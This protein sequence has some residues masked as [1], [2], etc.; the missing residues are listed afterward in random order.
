MMRARKSKRGTVLVMIVGLLAMLFMLVSAYITLARFDRQITRQVARGQKTEQMIRA[1]QDLVAGQIG[2]SGV[3]GNAGYAGIPGQAG[4]TWLAAPEI[5]RNPDVDVDAANPGDYA[6][7]AVSN[8][9]GRSSGAKKLTQL[10]RD[11]DDT[12]NAEARVLPAG[13]GSNATTVGN[14]REPFMDAT[15]AGISD[16]SFVDVALGTEMAN[17]MSGQTVS[18]TKSGAGLNPSDLR[19]NATPGTLESA[20]YLGWQRFDAEARYQTPVRVEG[21]GGKVLI[22]LPKDPAGSAQWNRQFIYNQF[23]WIKSVADNRDYLGKRPGAVSDTTSDEYLLDSV[24]NS[25]TL[26]EP[27]LRQRGGLLAGQRGAD[28]AYVPPALAALQERFYNT[29]IPPYATRVGTDKAWQRFNLT[30][31]QDWKAWAK[32]MTVDPAPLSVQT[33]SGTPT[34]Y[35]AR[36]NLTTENNSDDLA[37][38]ENTDVPT[39]AEPGLYSGQLKFYLGRIRRAYDEDATGQSGTHQFLHP[40]IVREL[41]TYYAELLRP[42]PE[43][44]INANL[45]IISKRKQAFMLAVNTVQFAARR[46]E[47]GRLDRAWITDGDDVY[48][49]YGP[50]PF[51][52]QVIACRTKDDPND[53]ALAI[54]LYNPNEPD[55]VGFSGAAQYSQNLYL[56]QFAISLQ[57]ESPKIPNPA[58]FRA[59]DPTSASVANMPEYMPGRSFKT[60]IINAGGGNTYFEN[61]IVNGQSLPRIIDLSVP[62]DAGSSKIHVRLLC[63]MLT[64][65]AILGGGHAWVEVDEFELERPASAPSANDPNDPNAI[66]PTWTGSYVDAWR[67]TDLVGEAGSG[68]S[69]W[70]NYGGGADYARW[71]CVAA[72]R[73]VPPTGGTEQ[74]YADKQNDAG[75]PDDADSG[76]DGKSRLDHLGQPGP[77]N[78]NLAG[79]AFGPLTPMVTMSA[80]TDSV[81]VHGAKRPASFPTVGFMAFIPR[82][83]HEVSTGGSLPGSTPMGLLLYRR[84]FGRGYTTPVDFGHMPIFDNLN[85]NNK[86]LPWGLM[87]FDYF[88]TLD[89]KGV[90][91]AATATADDIDPY[92]IPGRIDINTAPWY[93]L[94][95]LPML[96]ASDL[97]PAYAT[98]TTAASPAFWSSAAG[99]L[100]GSG[101]D[102]TPRVSSVTTAG[103]STNLLNWGRVGPVAG[104]AMAAYRDRVPYVKLDT[105]EGGL[106]YYAYGRNTAT[107]GGVSLHT[108]RDSSRYGPI[109]GQD[110]ATPTQFGFLSLGEL[111]NV[112]GMDGNDSSYDAAGRGDYVRAVSLLARLDTHFLTTR[113]NTFTIYTTLVDR[114]NPQASVRSQVTIDRSKLLP[115]LVWQDTNNNG[116]MDPP[117]GNTTDDVY[118]TIQNTGDPEIIGDREIGYYNTRYDN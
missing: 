104:K 76:G 114:R 99:V 85:G 64:S 84:W 4:T 42:Y 115:R 96:D 29:L 79:T 13:T 27:L 48:V 28:P 10:M 88:T 77:D 67:D 94:A 56:P 15:G 7:P 25:R 117:V 69:Y 81:W 21:H 23:N 41:V 47:S 35:A 63:Q 1:L 30:S 109:R 22:G 68:A 91:Q 17:T 118:T 8:L 98:F 53:I 86:Q 112:P 12:D 72:V 45:G 33:W 46:M 110:E 103:S 34:T 14:A 113:S 32:A 9:S 60:I 5:V 31:S 50:Q 116:I 107:V 11:Y 111:V 78:P 19:S 26:I 74:H 66:D 6:Y 52:T 80:G 83:A 90:D 105:N 82:Y 93:V 75:L 43:P 38:K 24:W 2:Q 57:S 65:P 71:R 40:G 36:R 70:G 51:I 102:S 49:G 92:R 18:V 59:L 62:T 55:P 97:L 108:W 95:G 58:H 37:R 61:H 89:P 54:E 73:P 3:G 44:T 101:A 87:V 100:F 16:S 106:F 20:N 39:A